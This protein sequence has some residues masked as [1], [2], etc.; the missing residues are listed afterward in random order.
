MSVSAFAPGKLILSGEHAVV[1]GHRALAAA[2]SLGTTV[3]LHSQAGPTVIR[4]ANFQDERLLPALLTVLPADGIGVEIESSLPIGCGMGSSAALAVATVRAYAKRMGTE[5]DFSRCYEE[6]F[7]MERL[8]HGTPSG[9]DHSISALGGLV[10]YRRQADGPQIEKITLLR[11]LYLVVVDSGRPTQSTAELVAGV[12]QR[13][14]TRT[15]EA[16]GALTERV[17]AAMQQNEEV[18]SLL[19]ENHRLLQ[20]LGVSTPELDRVVQQLR[21]AGALGAK[22]AGAGGGGVAFG[23]LPDLAA[24]NQ[25][26]ARLR[27]GGRSAWAVAVG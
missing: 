16:I 2:V 17:I 9:I 25:A 8:F 23:L 26:V 6:A 12:R 20:E 10:A 19:N 15:L 7:R 5:A 13:A 22:L 18:G 4:K 21:E 27:H 3:T 11:P 14:P 24:Q 1:Y